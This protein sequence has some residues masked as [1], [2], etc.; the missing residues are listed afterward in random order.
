MCHFTAISKKKRLCS[1]F[2]PITYSD[3]IIVQYSKGHNDSK[4]TCEDVRESCYYLVIVM[5]SPERQ[6]RFIYDAE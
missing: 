5:L 3:M 4:G 2:F 6:M 1:F